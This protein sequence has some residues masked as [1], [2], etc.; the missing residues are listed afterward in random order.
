[1]ARK[2]LSSEQ[3]I[4]AAVALIEQGGYDR[5]SIRELAQRLGVQPSS[6]YNH[7]A[8]IDEVSVAVGIEAAVRMNQLLSEK[9]AQLPPEAA[10]LAAAR[11]YR[12]FALENPEL[13]KA[14]MRMPAAQNEALTRA[15][16]MGIAPLRQLIQQVLPEG[17]ERLHFTRAVRAALH[18]YVSLEQAG[19][20]HLGEISP[21]ESF[22]AMI[23]GFV[24]ALRARA[25]A[26]TAG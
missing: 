22:D 26:R 6:L 21:E 11:A 23:Q 16:M 1:M 9:V 2:G 20:L 13:Y 17:P 5:F 14:L 18:G 15:S 19:F 10:F 4:Q 8:G 7:I 24:G 3:I 25:S 12:A